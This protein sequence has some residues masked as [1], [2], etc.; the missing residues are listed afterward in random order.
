MTVGAAYRL[1]AGSATASDTQ[2][3]NK[4]QRRGGSTGRHFGVED[5]ELLQFEEVALVHHVH[6]GG[7]PHGAPVGPLQHQEEVLAHRHQPP[8]RSDLK[9]AKLTCSLVPAK[10]A[11]GKDAISGMATVVDGVP[12]AGAVRAVALKGLPVCTPKGEAVMRR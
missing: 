9:H 6:G 3:T 12:A 11:I 4:D 2:E 8:T 7:E 1:V 10:D 5:A